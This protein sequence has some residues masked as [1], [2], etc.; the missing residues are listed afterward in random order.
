[1]YIGVWKTLSQQEQY[2]PINLGHFYKK[3]MSALSNLNP[4][5]PVKNKTASISMHITL[6]SF[7]Y[8]KHYNMTCKLK[9]NVSLW[10]NKFD[11]YL[12]A[13]YKLGYLTRSIEKDILRADSSD[14]RL[15]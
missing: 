3:L 12:K 9:N 11:V 8:L 7:Q 5:V 10:T 1:M 2:P 6:G 13:S 4:K 15:F 14:E